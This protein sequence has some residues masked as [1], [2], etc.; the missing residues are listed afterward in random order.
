[1]YTGEDPDNI[2]LTLRIYGST[3]I[4]SDGS[5]GDVSRLAC[6]F[7]GD[8]SSDIAATFVSPTVIHCPMFEVSNASG[9]NRCGANGTAGQ[10]QYI[11][12]TW[13]TGGILKTDVEV[14]I[15]INGVDHLLY[16]LLRRLPACY[17]FMASLLA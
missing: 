9:T 12:F 2:A 16:Q 11:P 8:S 3:F 10:A 5:S 13:L 17:T 15:T 7:Y 4:D 6:G 14:S 1:M